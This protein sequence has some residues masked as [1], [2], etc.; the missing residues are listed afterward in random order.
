MVKIVWTEISLT[1]LKEVF[2][3]IAEDSIRYAS[4]TVD[5]IYNRVQSISIYPYS[6]RIVREFNEEILREVIEGRYR[7]IY[8]I[9]SNTQIDIIRVYHT[10]RLLRKKDII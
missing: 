2:D 3:F 6:G 8:R 1:D 4:I 10:S 9:K 7:I 5:R